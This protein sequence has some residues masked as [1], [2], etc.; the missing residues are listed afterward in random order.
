MKT[1]SIPEKLHLWFFIYLVFSVTWTPFNKATRNNTNSTKIEILSKFNHHIHWVW[2]VCCLFFLSHT[3]LYA[4]MACQTI[5]PH[6]Q[7][8]VKDL[9][10]TAAPRLQ[11]NSNHTVFTT[12][13]IRNI[14]I[15]KNIFHHFLPLIPWRPLKHIVSYTQI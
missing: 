10:P 12:N 5:K 2:R 4:M 7:F 11:I 1:C 15:S 13:I 6:Q 14:L 9:N 3:F 8:P